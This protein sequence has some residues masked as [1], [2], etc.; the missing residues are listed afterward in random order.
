MNRRI[1]VAYSSESVVVQTTL[2]YLLSFQNLEGRVHY[3][4]VTHDALIDV[5]P[6][7]YDVLINNY[8]ARLHR[9][10]YVS[11]S[12]VR[13]LKDFVGLKILVVQD[14]YDRTN[15][16][17]KAI[18][19]F[20]FNVVLTC[21]PAE[22]IHKIYP[23][24]E[25]HGVR[26]VTVLTGYV[27]DR[28]R[29]RASKITSLNRRPIAVGY[30]GRNLGAR[31]GRLAFEKFEIGRRMKEVCEAR[32]ISNDIA[33]SEESR[34]YGE[35]WFDFIGSCRTMLGSESG[36]NVF[37]FDGSLDELY[38]G[39][40]DPRGSRLSYGELVS[41]IQRRE[42]M[43]E[44]GQISPRVF[45]CAAL[46]TP[47]IL[48]RGTYSG[49]I[50]PYVHYIPLEKDFANVDEVL[51]RIEDLDELQAMAARACAA[52]VES[53]RF[54]YRAF[55]AKLQSIISEMGISW[56]ERKAVI[57]TQVSQVLGPREHIL[58]ISPT[59]SPQRGVVP[60]QRRQLLLLAWRS[61]VS[62][63]EEREGEM[64][65]AFHAG[66]EM[67]Q[68]RLLRG[69]SLGALGIATQGRISRLRKE[70]VATAIRTKSFAR[71]TKEARAPQNGVAEGDLDALVELF[72]RR[73]EE[74]HL[75]TAHLSAEYKMI[76][77]DVVLRFL[78]VEQE[79]A[80]LE[81]KEEEMLG[82]F[83]AGLDTMQERL[84]RGQSLGALGIETQ[85][86]I[87]QLRKELVATAIRTE[88]F[89]RDS[90]EARP[91]QNG[92]RDLDA[93]VELFRCRAQE[94]HLRTAHLSAEYKLIADDVV[95]RFLGVKQEVEELEP[96]EKEMLASF[97]AGLDE[98]EQKLPTRRSLASRAMEISR[99]IGQLRKELAASV[100]DAESFAS[101][102]AEAQ[103]SFNGG[104]SDNLDVL[105]DLFRRRVQEMYLRSARLSAD[106]T[107]IVEEV[108]SLTQ[109]R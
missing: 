95:L 55:A 62:T 48:F 37:D 97:R 29:Q 11:D 80:D 101:S 25:F 40:S 75:R 52:L 78:A 28:L 47:M 58:R 98:L 68:E 30:R 26:F 20:G 72:R 34:I 51:R 57:R 69:R 70:L 17:K 107:S 23:Y 106:Y 4:H 99:R 14:E 86:R 54:S 77:D 100:V 39:V 79:V 76:A 96:K 61:E 33:M 88:S 45:E 10:G 15:N 1:L 60:S 108:V 92:E 84:P 67:M 65:G 18:K 32:G 66:L 6:N 49:L 83:H 7:S 94:M 59:T 73:A 21:V 105:V 81:L 50:R 91:P 56:S 41:E 53:E 12:Y 102:S 43:I 42:S 71:D 2:D 63:L 93:L 103:L 19:Q 89:A 38:G 64:L 90:T 13:L 16:I 27:S 22:H 109:R 85:D 87:S 5:D 82:A 9:D 36:S 31:Y 35:A 24:E 46:K 3:V 44:M 104:S 74:M 8:C